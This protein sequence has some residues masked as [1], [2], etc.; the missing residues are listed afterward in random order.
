MASTERDQ[1]VT[2]RRRARR[3]ARADQAWTD[4]AGTGGAAVNGFDQTFDGDSLYALR[5]AVAAHATHLGLTEARVADLVLVAHEL[6]SN[7][8]RH[9]GATTAAPG[10]IE[11]WRE[12]RTLLCRVS[13][14]GPGIADP[15]AR[16][17]DDVPL[18][19]AA[20]A[21]SGSSG[22]WWI[23]STSAATP[24]HDDHRRDSS[25]PRPRPL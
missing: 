19:P 18:A 10:R 22:R 1:R 23:A 3:P 9:G 13:D 20:A 24:R 21:G 25:R 4:L 8:V 2:Q 11:L 6:A 17:L 14:S 16:R 15:H 5:S 7:A 12:D